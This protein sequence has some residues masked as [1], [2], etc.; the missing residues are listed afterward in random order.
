MLSSTA[1]DEIFHLFAVDE[2]DHVDVFY[3]IVLAE[4]FSSEQCSEREFRTPLRRSKGVHRSQFLD[5][6]TL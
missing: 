4:H 2:N 6:K 3:D 5:K 1:N